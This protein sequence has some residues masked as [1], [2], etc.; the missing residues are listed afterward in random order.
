[1]EGIHITNPNQ[2]NNETALGIEF[3][4]TRIK[5]VR[6]NRSREV[7]ESGSHHWESKFL[8]G[9]W[10]YSLEDVEAGLKDA[11][12]KLTD[13]AGPATAIGISAM[14]H[15][16]LVFDKDGNLLVPFRTWKDSTTKESADKL[17]E[18]FEF[19]IP[20]RWSVAHLYQAVLNKEPHVKDIAFITTLAGY[21]HW[22]LTG[23]KVIGAGDASG[24]F[25]ISGGTW[26]PDFVDKFRELT[27]IDWPAIAPEI[28]TAGQDAGSL[29]DEGREYLFGTGKDIA[30]SSC[31]LCPP[32]GDAGTGM[33]SCKAIAPGTGN[34]S[35]GTSI[36]AMIVLEKPLS[37]LYREIDIVTT[38]DGR[39]VAMVHYNEC[40][41]RIDP[42]IEL[43]AEA[44]EFFG[45][46]ID[47]RELYDGLY[48][49]ALKKDSRLGA[50]MRE[51]LESAVSDLAS[52]IRVLTEDEHVRVDRLAGHGGFFKSG[53]AGRTIMSELTGIPIELSETAAEG[54][55]WGIALL[56]DYLNDADQ[57]TLGEYLE[58]K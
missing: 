51:T 46:K 10:T 55:A 4:S 25:P 2:T 41:S 38:P 33:V 31:R 30:A 57:M 28:L 23:R 24:M 16:Y 53:L 3:G 21:V 11:V 8:G 1:M 58:A 42:R 49:Y 13:A 20:E 37:K 40:T 14:M 45:R 47:T 9:H 22:R 48:E 27:G 52:G 7:L 43:F 44:F 36:F 35:A 19:N 34:V 18:L 56:A 17:T 29:T 5:A 15:G 50:F 32:E 26:N 12:S 39:D 54:G 6:I